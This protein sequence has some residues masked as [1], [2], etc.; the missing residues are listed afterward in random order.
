MEGVQQAIPTIGADN[1]NIIGLVPP[2]WPRVDE[3]ERIAAILEAVIAVIAFTYIKYVR[4]AKASAVLER[5]KYDHGR[6]SAG[7]TASPV[8]IDAVVLAI[9]FS[10][11]V[12]ISF[13]Y[14]PARKAAYLHP[15]EALRSE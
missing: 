7:S 12:G 5:R 6:P 8:S 2:S 13:G 9:A 3:H 11:L 14:Y 15:I 4:I 1:V 10:A